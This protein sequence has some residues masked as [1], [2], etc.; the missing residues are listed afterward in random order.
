VMKQ[1]EVVERG[2]AG[3]IFNAPQTAYTQRLI[4]AAFDL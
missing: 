2:T 3:Q 1:G 4:A